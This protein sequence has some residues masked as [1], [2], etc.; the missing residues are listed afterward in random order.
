M[1][2][3]FTAEKVPDVT[4][5]ALELKSVKSDPKRYTP[6][7]ERIVSGLFIVTP[8]VVIVPPDLPPNPIADVVEVVSIPE[9]NVSDPMICMMLAVGV[10]V[11]DVPH[12]E[13][14]KVISFPGYVVSIVT[15]DAPAKA[16]PTVTVSCGSGFRVFHLAIV[17]QLKLLVPF[18][19]TLVGVV[20]VIPEF[21]PQS[22]ERPVIAARFHEPAPA[23]T[24]S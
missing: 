22:P 3:P 13:P 17:D 5:N 18:A 16:R 15:T 10:I 21:P 12:V 4:P 6:D 19:E 8:L 23:P 14:A 7:P 2:A 9:M 24:M 1:L 20:N 11:R